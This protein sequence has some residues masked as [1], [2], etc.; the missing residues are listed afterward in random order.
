MRFL[1]TFYFYFFYWRC[2]PLW[3]LAFSVIFFPSALSSHCFLHRLTFIRAIRL[4]SLS[5]S[6]Q[7][8][9][10]GQT[11]QPCAQPLTWRTIY[12]YTKK[13]LSDFNINPSCIQHIPTRS[14]F[15][16]FRQFESASIGACNSSLC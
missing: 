7:L 8:S 9:F 16:I 3:V 14:L 6:Q 15:F 2:N 5:S 1:L 13:T 11:R 10:P 12:M 4:L